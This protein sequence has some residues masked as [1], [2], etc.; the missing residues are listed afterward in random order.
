MKHDFSGKMHCFEV[1]CFARFF[2]V[3]AYLTAG[4]ES[5]PADEKAKKAVIVYR[6]FHC[7]SSMA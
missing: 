2:L 1:R 3:L 7:H 6:L 5:G 4:F